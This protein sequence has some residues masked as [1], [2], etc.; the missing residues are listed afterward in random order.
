LKRL[1]L[2][3]GGHAHV[4][5]LREMAQQPMA[6]AQVTL[7]SPFPRQMYSGMVPGLVAGHYNAAECTIPLLPL[8]KAAGITFV[9]GLVTSINAR[10]RTARLFTGQELPYDVMSVDIGPVA[11]A[12]AIPGARGRGLFVRPIEHFVRLLEPMWE[13]AMRR[14]LD[15][16]VIGGGAGGFELAMAFA[17]RLRQLGDGSSRVAIVTGDAAPLGTYLGRVARMAMQALRAQGVTVLQETCVA[18]EDHHVLLG[19]GARVAC[20]SPVVATGAAAAPWLSGTGL[21]VD[22]RGFITVGPTMQSTSHLEV[23]AAGDVATRVDAPHP[24]SGVYAVRAGPPLALNLRRYVAG[25]ELV[26][27]L[28]QE[29]TL[30]LMSCGDRRAIANW[31]PWSTQGRWVWCWKDHIDRGFIA[32][33][34]PQE[35][36]EAVSRAAGK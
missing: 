22:G 19:N 35:G 36:L 8:A 13:L 17:W 2:L 28:P 11:D 30:N 14:P 27:Y 24:R 3:G 23:F 33:Y 5:V 1:L 20:D 15:V 25:G 6:G 16:V 18:I 12:D 32:R 31:G 7:V 26:P 29:R 21:D 4:H 9:E 34:S 10:A